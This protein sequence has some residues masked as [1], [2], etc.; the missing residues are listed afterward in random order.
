[1][2]LGPPRAA[3][4]TAPVYPVDQ[5]PGGRLADAFQPE[6]P[7]VYGGQHR[8]DRVVKARRLGHVVV[9]T[10]SLS[11]GRP[12]GGGYLPEKKACALRAISPAGTSSMC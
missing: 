11:R 6:D 7:L 5:D 12:W 4:A 2:Q 9:T 1:M 10:T 3:C 8:P